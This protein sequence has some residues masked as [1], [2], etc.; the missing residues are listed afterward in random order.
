LVLSSFTLY[1]GVISWPSRLAFDTP[2][3]KRKKEVGFF[4]CLCFAKGKEEEG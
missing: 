4:S 2:K 1:V 3:K